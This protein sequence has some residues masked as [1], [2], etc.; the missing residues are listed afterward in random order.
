M[1]WK[2]VV[3]WV[4]LC[5]LIAYVAGMFVWARVQAA[6]H[7]C[8][9]IE[10]EIH[11]ANQVSAITSQSVRD[12]L[13]DYPATIVGEPLPS[14]NTFEIAEYLRK[15]NN[16]ETVECM[17]TT[18][19]H[20][21]VRVSPMIPAIRVFDGERSYYVNKDGKTMT[22]LPAFH[23]DVP[24]VAGHFDEHFRPESVLPLINYIS[25][26]S[27]LN[28]LVGMVQANDIE[29]LILVPRIRGHVINFGDTTRLDEKRDALLTAYRSIIPYKG[30]ETY[31]T[32]SVK[33][34]GQIVATRRD[35]TPL[36][37]IASLEE[38]EDSE[39]ASLQA[40]QNTTE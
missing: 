12:V 1:E 22:A 26:D 19:G 15:F 34:K 2:G 33:Y 23:V 24:I 39:E 6:H 7:V 10:V 31:D 8:T 25:K 37:P 32:I 21:K 27:L 40:T 20:L 11:G 4:I 30:W 17:I 28:N 13:K 5:C 14:I 16:F 18:Q 35:K 36:F 9:A 3:K 38:E 29:N